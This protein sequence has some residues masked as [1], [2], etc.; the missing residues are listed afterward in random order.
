VLLTYWN[1]VAFQVLYARTS[2]WS[3]GSVPAPP[4]SE[5][6]VLDRWLH[7]ET[8]RLVVEVTTSFEGF[9]T[10]RI[11]S[12]LGQFVDDLSN[13]YVRRSRRRFWEGDPAALQTLH[14]ALVTLT[15]LMAPL[16]PFITER[17]WQDLVVPV[18]PDAPPS[19]HLSSWPTPDPA[20]VDEDLSA[21]VAIARRLVEL[22]RA[23]RAEAKVK[24]R[25]PLR[26][27]LIG[28]AAHDR[29]SDELRA[30]V[31]D[32]LNLGSVE[33]LS[34]AG[35]DLVDHTA[36]GNFR[37]LGKRFAKETPKVAAAIAAA[38]AS[39]LAASLAATGA[40]N[41]SV[42]GAEVEV[43]AEEVIVSERPRE[44]WAVLNEQGETV[45]LDLEITP[46]LRR[47]GLAREV[48]RLIQETRKNSGFDVSDRIALTWKAAGEME[49]AILEHR[50]LIAREVL[51]TSMAEAESVDTLTVHDD[52]LG[53]SFTVFRG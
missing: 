40:A 13:W 23:A 10:Q 19:V 15:Q 29:L 11:G 38:D 17:V 49:E 45:A 30:E 7:A 14:D 24:I 31:A 51:A 37:A 3:P 48:I 53:F 5:R 47:A 4:V 6:P 46:E 52:E 20:A 1:S 9:D 8:A 35:A 33:P 28:T 21:S 27:A 22:G 12:L 2:G 32:E 34:A 16:V 25:Q 36:K 42:E 44:G 26:R 50:E 39:A 18:T 43:T 41:V